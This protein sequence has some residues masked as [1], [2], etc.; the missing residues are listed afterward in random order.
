MT[1]IQLTITPDEQKG[2]QAVRGLLEGELTRHTVP[3]LTNKH[4]KKLF[5]CATNKNEIKNI[6]TLD[7]C[8]VTKVDTAGLA[9]L[10]QQIEL[11][12]ANPCQLVFAHL[13]SELIKL[14]K[15]SGVDDFLI[16]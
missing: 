13:P 2:K 7:L 9:W 4:S 16:P 1:I 15:L 14:A 11:A 6:V 5:S 10:L 3:Q 8:K 12:Q